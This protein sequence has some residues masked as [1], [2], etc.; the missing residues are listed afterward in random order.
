M[1]L[2][3]TPEELA[4]RL[5]IASSEHSHKRVL[6]GAIR[7]AMADVEAYLGRVI[8][9]TE[10]TETGRY[11]VGTGWNLTPQDHPVR[12]IVSVVAETV[13]DPPVPTGYF[14]VTYLAG[15]DCTEPKYRPILRYIT[16]HAMNDPA[17][18]RL[19]EQFSSGARTITSV[20]AEGQSVTYGA[21]SLGGGGAAGSGAPGALPTKASLDRWRVAGRRAFVRRTHG[22]DL[23]AWPYGGALWGSGRW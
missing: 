15:I 10:F 8:V 13:G 7:D 14:T 2:P 19:W 18:V 20:S 1:P 21:A 5:G 17:V 11:D 6:E 3:V 22:S 9:P 23:D 12:S 16:A 4:D